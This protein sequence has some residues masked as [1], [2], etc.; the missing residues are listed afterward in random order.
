MQKTLG[1]FAFIVGFILAASTSN[2]FAQTPPRVALAPVGSPPNP[3]TQKLDYTAIATVDANG[4]P[5]VKLKEDVVG[6][7]FFLDGFRKASIT[8]T[9]GTPYKN[10]DLLVDEEKHEIHVVYQGHEIVVAD[11]SVREF[12]ILDTLE[13]KGN[14]YLFRSGYPAIDKNSIHSFYQVLSNGKLALLRFGK[15]QLV[16]SKDPISGQESGEYKN[17]E[18]YYVFQNGKIM[19]IK[20]EKSFLTALMVDQSDKVNQFIKDQRVNFKKISSIVELIN[21]YNSL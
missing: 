2:L 1:Y 13:G 20:K 4:R 16:I 12:S 15:K 14:F 19:E 17:Y 21:Y 18:S 10:I 11:G 9:N 8:L 3:F 5:F 7:P 6:S